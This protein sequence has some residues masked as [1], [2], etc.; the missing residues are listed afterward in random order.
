[1]VPF[2][3]NA[4]ASF[5]EPVRIQLRVQPKPM[6]ILGPRRVMEFDRNQL[7]Y[8]AVR[9]RVIE[10]LGEIRTPSKYVEQSS[11]AHVVTEAVRGIL[12]DVAPK[13]RKTPHQH[14]ISQRTMKLIEERDDACRRSANLGRAIQKCHAAVADARPDFATSPQAGSTIRFQASPM[15][16]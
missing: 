12:E 2:V 1:M 6:F 10:R 8:P 11:R 13:S 3:H 15:Q 16:D 9:S 4:A 14:W 5:H 7:A